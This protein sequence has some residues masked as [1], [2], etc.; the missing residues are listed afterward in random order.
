MEKR[1]FKTYERREFTKKEK[2]ERA[3]LGNLA[4]YFRMSD[5]EREYKD[6]NNWKFLT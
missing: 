1:E 5:I 3:I 2:D 4:Y 6:S